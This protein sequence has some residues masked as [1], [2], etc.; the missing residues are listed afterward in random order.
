MTAPDKLDLQLLKRRAL[1]LA[2]MLPPQLSTT[3]PLQLVGQSVWSLSRQLISAMPISED[4]F[5]FA[6]GQQLFVTS[7]K[8]QVPSSLF[9]TSIATQAK[10][11][12]RSR[13]KKMGE[14]RPQP[15]IGSAIWD[16]VPE[17]EPCIRQGAP[18]TADGWSMMEIY[19]NMME[20]AGRMVWM[21]V[22]SHK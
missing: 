6:A 15:Q 4:D 20:N 17:K 22:P 7:E 3:I 10:A 1:F 9:M 21:H 13:L 12:W 5:G 11:P 2:S 8:R 16:T 19:G 18:R 14:C